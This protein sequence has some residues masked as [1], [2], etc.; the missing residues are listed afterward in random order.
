MRFIG[1]KVNLLNNIE[2]V[3]NENVQNTGGV[4]CD[5]FSGTSSVAQHFKPQYEIIS[6]DALYFSYVIQKATIENNKTP[7]FNSLQQIGILDPISFLEDTKITTFNYN[8]DKYFIAKNYTPHDDCERMYFSNKN[9]VRI[10]FIRITIEAWKKANLLTELEYYYLL[11]ALI[12]GV[13]SVSNITGTYGAYLKQWDKRSHKELELLRL[14]VLD[15]GRNNKCYNKDALK[16][17][18]E[19]EGNIIYI[20]PPYNERQYAP[21]YHLLETISKYDYPEIKGVTGMRPYAEQK[22]PFCIKSQVHDAFEELI[23][24]A[25]FNNVVLSYSTDGI[26]S[27]EE[28]EGVLKKYGLPNTYK[29]YTIPYRKYKSKKDN[30]EH[31]LCEYLFYVKKK[32]DHKSYYDITSCKNK[33]YSDIIKNNKPSTK[34]YIKSP[35]NYIGGKY[36]ILPQ[37]LPHFPSDIHT[38]VDLFSGGCNVAINTWAD[39]IICNDINSIIVELFQYFQNNELSKILNEIETVISEFE[40]SKTNEDGFKELRNRY[41]N[42]RTPIDLYVLSCYSFNYQFRFNSNHEYNNPFG[43]NRS[44]FSESMRNSLIKFVTKLHTSDI[45]F[46]TKDFVDFE[47]D[48]L[49]AGDF[50]YCDPPYLITTGSYNDGNRGFKDWGIDEEQQLYDFLDKANEKGIRFAFSNVLE[51]KGK[52]NNMLIE[53]SQ[54]YKIIDINRDYS[55]SSYNTGR[56]QSREVLI[57]NY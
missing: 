1:S 10:D 45:S 21:N 51:H 50:I 36:K 38:F 34:K 33:T 17:I 8:D 31:T 41:N 37:I 15:N 28:I 30:S 57:I 42:E 7:D 3:I 40:L 24:K 47:I 46:T 23:S 49:N 6:N 22:S 29:K 20:D 19:I 43:R 12:E 11:A 4:F 35:T 56:G 13:P 2:A 9:A 52:T 32:I 14:N 25:K 54:K 26:M 27:D 18:T 55:N 53:W 16:L 48:D 39:K 44:Q 5:I